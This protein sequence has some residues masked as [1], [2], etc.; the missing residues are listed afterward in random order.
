MRA[1]APR[2]GR[3][4][5]N[6]AAAL[7]FASAAISLYWTLGGTAWLDS[8]GG[9]VEE[10]A[11]ERSVP[12]VAA[13]ALTVI[14][15]CAAGLLALALVRPAWSRAIGRGRLLLAGTLASGVLILW[16][17]ANVIIGGLVLLDVIVPTEAVDEYALRAHVLVWDMW[18]VLWGAAL[19]SAVVRVRG[20]PH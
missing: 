10:L 4:A 5:A 2:P 19:A 6:A 12:A 14:L 3:A 16:G 9:A 13:G 18:F 1:S 17:G 20:E 7:A 8:V 11:R 15:K